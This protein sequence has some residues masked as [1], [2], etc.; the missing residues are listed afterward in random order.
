V[1]ERFRQLRDDDRSVRLD[2]SQLEFID[3]SGVRVIVLGLKHAR[4]AG[5]Q[6]EVDDRISSTVARMIDIMGIGSQLWPQDPP[7]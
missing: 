1:E 2:L 4:Q 6:L 7:G 5:H 3:S